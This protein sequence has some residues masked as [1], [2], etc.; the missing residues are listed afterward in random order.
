MAAAINWVSFR[1]HLRGLSWG[2]SPLCCTQVKCRRDTRIIG[3]SSEKAFKGF[4][5]CVGFLALLPSEAEISSMKP[6][7]SGL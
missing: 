7:S 4:L 1:K 3:L 2:E 5:V 6:L